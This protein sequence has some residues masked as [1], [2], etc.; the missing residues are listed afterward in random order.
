MKTDHDLLDELIRYLFESSGAPKEQVD[1]TM[2]QYRTM[3]LANLKRRPP[4]PLTDADY[5]AKLAEMKK[6][7]PAFLEYLLAGNFH[8]LPGRFRGENN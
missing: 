1:L 8:P 3:L 2:Q 6:E 4:T 5:A 7:A